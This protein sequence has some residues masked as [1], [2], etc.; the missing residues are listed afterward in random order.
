MT[1]IC[2]SLPRWYGVG[3][4]RIQRHHTRDEYIPWSTEYFSLNQVNR[5]KYTWRVCCWPVGVHNGRSKGRL[6]IVEEKGFT[7][8]FDLHQTP[9]PR[10][11][12]Q[13]IGD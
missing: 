9:S 3:A 12:W 5:L 13:I 1:Q 7:S 11:C 2:N 6:L 8:A 4:E 10:W